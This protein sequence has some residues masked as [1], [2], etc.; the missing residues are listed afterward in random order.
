MIGKLAIKAVSSETPVGTLSG[1]N[2]QKVAIAKWL[3]SQARIYLLYDL[4]RGIDVGTKQEIYRL[5]R[6]MADDGM[7]LLFF[8]TDLSEIVNLCD[9][10]MVMYEGRVVRTVAGADLTEDNLVSAALNLAEPVAGYSAGQVC[11]IHAG[12]E[13]YED[14]N[15][16]NPCTLHGQDT[17]ITKELCVAASVTA[18]THRRRRRSFLSRNAPVLLAYLAFLILMSLYIGLLPRFSAAQAI[19]IANQGM[20]LAIAAL[21][22]TIVILTGGVDLSVGPVIAL[23]NSIAAT[24]MTDN[25][26]QVMLVVLLVL[27]VGMLWPD[28]W[29]GGRLRPPTADRRHAGD[30]VD[31]HW[32]RAVYPA[33]ARRLCARMVHECA[34]HVDWRSC[35]LGADPACA[36]G[37]PLVAV[38]ALAAGR[39]HLCD[40]QQRGVG[41]YV[42][43][44]AD[45]C[46]G[47]GLHAG[48]AGERGQLACSSP[49]RPPPARRYRGAYSHSIRSRRSCWA[50][51]VWLAAAAAISG[52]SRAR[53]SSR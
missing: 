6:Q 17:S 28:Q 46:Q 40:W 51:R 3:L 31:L 4:T 15:G 50:A 43:H 32:L 1:G 22:Q 13:D 14:R 9:R 21:G 26:A 53:M 19:S 11:R 24:L 7:G 39:Q 23:T 48:R 45:P 29:P 37:G 2:Q 20:T 42:G 18:P 34:H 49:P 12:H 8:S 5:M 33:A 16:N 27:A 47:G 35:A 25:P 30:L 44:L 36:A 10:A 38:Q 41:V 52:Q